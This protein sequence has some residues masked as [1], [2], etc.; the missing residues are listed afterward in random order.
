MGVLGRDCEGDDDHD[1][2]LGGELGLRD[3]S[4]DCLG[5]LLVVCHLRVSFLG[6]ISVHVFACLSL[7][8]QVRKREEQKEHL[9]LPTLLI[10]PPGLPVSS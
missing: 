6:W 2:A 10:S 1:R 4:L 3:E 7:S 5:F 9:K 8:L